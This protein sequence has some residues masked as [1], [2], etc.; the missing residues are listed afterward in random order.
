[1]K[2]FWNS[3]L[4]QMIGIFCLNAV[5]VVS[6]MF[7]SGRATNLS[8][9][10]RAQATTADDMVTNGY[11]LITQFH[12]YIDADTENV[13]AKIKATIDSFNT[14]TIS[15]LDTFKQSDEA[16][17]NA[18]F[19]PDEPDRLFDDIEPGYQKFDAA[20]QQLFNS[21]PKDWEKRVVDVEITGAAFSDIGE[22]LATSVEGFALAE[23]KNHSNI[24]AA[25]AS[26]IALS[27]T[28]ATIVIIQA[29]RS[30]SRLVKTTQT[31]ANGDYSVR[32]DLHSPNEIQ[33]IGRTFNQMAE[34][35][36]GL[37]DELQKQIL[38]ANEARTQAEKADQVKSSFLASVSH[39]L[40]TPL[41]AI[42]NFSKFVIKG[43]M[44]P[45]TDQQTDALNKVVDSGKHLL[46]LINDVLDISKIESGSL[47]LFLEPNINVEKIIV[48][49]TALAMA[50]IE[51]KPVQLRIQMEDAL[52]TIHA[53]RQR[54]RQIFTNILSNACKF[55]EEGFIDV[56]VQMKND[57]LLIRVQD[58][59]PG[60]AAEDYGL[61]FESFKQTSTGL[62]QGSGTGLG[63]PISKRLTEALGGKLWFESEVGKGS[64]FFVSLPVH[65]E[66][67]SL[68]VA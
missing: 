23:E 12:M 16:L 21:D 58:T 29:V 28:V 50:L 3:L 51:G 68:V 59:G 48:D 6:F 52:P 35:I 5:L 49:T 2:R 46:N 36:S 24:L 33:K 45:V 31:F 30:I 32:A 7:I 66:E 34:E 8:D 25:I 4:I 47:T 54:L 44:G 55:T 10:T 27:L 26:G 60:I 40:R 53:D 37:F 9:M 22:K 63:M 64:T 13:R 61:V 65:S 20:M 62:R 39:E 38:V 41:N 67:K 42:I 18:G 1:M 14:E 57:E 11:K 43:V 15:L 56:G 19:A 17:D